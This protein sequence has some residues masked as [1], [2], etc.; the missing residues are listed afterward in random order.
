ME[1]LRTKAQQLFDQLKVEKT[2][3]QTRAIEAEIT[4]PNFWNDNAT[5]SSKMKDLARLQK[6][7][8]NAEMLELLIHD[9][10]EEEL[11]R[12][13]DEME[14]YL[15]LSGPYD[16]GPAILT[17]HAG[18]GGADAMDWAHILYRMYTR[19]FERRGW[20]Y[21]II[22][23]NKGEEAGI[24]N[25]NIAV[26]GEHAYGYLRGERGVHRLVRLSPFNSDKLRHTSFALIDVLPQIEKIEGIELKEDDLEWDFYHASSHGGQNVQKVATAV[27]VTH[28][29]SGLIVT[30]QTE[31]SQ[32]QNRENA[33][34]LLKAKLWAKYQEEQKEEEKKFRGAYRA[35]SWGNQIRSYVLHPYQMVK[36]LRT[37][38]ETSNTQGVLDGELDEFTQEAVKLD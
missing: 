10:T 19:F 8:E 35:P 16:K 31:R 32:G 9:G 29:P 23:E 17:I 26:D 15:F 20:R 22:D 1:E 28:K 30:C 37:G 18:Q 7:L 11:S 21:E 6:E 36:D 38:V 24:K 34:K 13:M 33:L 25:V 2:R 5:A 12:L 14:V 3:Q 4:H 27:R